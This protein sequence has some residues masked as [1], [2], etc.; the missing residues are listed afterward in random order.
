MTGCLC[1]TYLQVWNA[2]RVVHIFQEVGLVVVRVNESR[3]RE[4]QNRRHFVRNE[5]HRPTELKKSHAKKQ[6]GGVVWHP[7][8]CTVTSTLTQEGSMGH[9]EHFV[10]NFFETEEKSYSL[11]AASK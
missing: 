11:V 6:T 3:C 4:Q 5:S 9:L 8:V 7:L 1:T 2:S 10:P